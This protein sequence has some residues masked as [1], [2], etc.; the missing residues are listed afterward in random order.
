PQT[1]QRTA[2]AHCTTA[3][4]S[5]PTPSPPPELADL[6]LEQRAGVAGRALGGTDPTID[7]WSDDLPTRVPSPPRPADATKGR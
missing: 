7:A 4:E 3:A 1:V 6:G 2:R 5:S